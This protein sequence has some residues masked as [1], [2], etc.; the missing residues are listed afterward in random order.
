MIESL[1][2]VLRTVERGHCGRD[3]QRKRW[4]N[5]GSLILQNLVLGP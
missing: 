2:N 5:R 1:Q 4:E 3:L